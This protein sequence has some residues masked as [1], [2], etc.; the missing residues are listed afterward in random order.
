MNTK[1]TANK[2]KGVVH[3][4]RGVASKVAGNFAGT[5]IAAR[6]AGQEIGVGLYNE[7]S[8]LPLRS[9]P[10]PPIKRNKRPTLDKK[11][12]QYRVKP[13]PDPERPV[14]Q[15]K[16]MTEKQIEE[17]AFKPSTQWIEAG[18]GGAGK[19][20]VEIIGC[21]NLPNMD[22]SV[23]GRDKTDCESPEIVPVASEH[24]SLVLT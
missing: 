16:W 10:N 23:T 2:R 18:T 7:N 15:T 14:E 17:E 9:H 3:Q 13:F 12:T 1:S 5:D 21:D 20:Y 19:Y 4:F 6:V 11:S 8:Y 24:Y 22:F